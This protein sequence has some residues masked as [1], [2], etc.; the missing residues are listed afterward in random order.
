MTSLKQVCGNIS[1][2]LRDFVLFSFPIDSSAIVKKDPELKTI[3]RRNL[4]L[5]TC[6][7]TWMPMMLVCLPI[8][9]E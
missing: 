3:P 2:A 9:D 4:F 6:K 5:E 1:H 8:K 7:N